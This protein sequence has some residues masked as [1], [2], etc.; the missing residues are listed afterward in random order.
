VNSEVADELMK[1]VKYLETNFYAFTQEHSIEVQLPFIQY[2]FGNNVKIVPIALWR[3]T[4][5]VA[6]NLGSAIAEVISS[7]KP[8]SIVYVASSDWNHYE[9]HEVT[10][11]KDMRAIDPV[12]RLDEDSFFDVLERYDASACGYGAIGFNVNDGTIY[13]FKVKVT[14]MYPR[15]CEFVGA[16]C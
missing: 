13:V 6:R 1:R 12:L 4:K 15:G 8:G 5:D 3:Q 7:H 16:A 11:E 2:I 9:L 14:I 10:T